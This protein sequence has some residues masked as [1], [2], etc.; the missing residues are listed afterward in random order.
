AK[1]RRVHEMDHRGVPR[2]ARRRDVRLREQ[3]L[4]LVEG[5]HL[6][7]PSS[8]ARTL[9]QLR[10]IRIDGALA[11]Q[12]AEEAAERRELARARSRAEAGAYVRDEEL[13]EVLR[14]D[15]PRIGDVA[16]ARSEAVQ[17]ARVRLERVPREG[18]LDAQ[19][20]EERVDPA[21]ELHAPDFSDARP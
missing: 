21:R 9:D 18:A 2:S 3:A 15:L 5:E 20:I 1:P 6:R 4:D 17:V 10:R 8:E 16:E 19:M 14:P 11:H 7:Q 13:G 12:E